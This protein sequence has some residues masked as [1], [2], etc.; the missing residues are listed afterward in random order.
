MIL[1]SQQEFLEDLHFGHIGE[2]KTLLQ[3][4]ECVY[5]PGIIENV[6]HHIR[7]CD[8]CQSTRPKQQK[9]LPILHDV[10]SGPWENVHT[11]PFQHRSNDCLLVAAYFSNFPLV[12]KLGNQ[13]AAHAV[14]LLK[15]IFS[16]HGIPAYLFT[17]EARQFMSAE[18]HE[19]SRFYQFEIL[20][21]TPRFPQSNGFIDAMVKILKQIISNIR[22]VRGKPPSCNVSLHG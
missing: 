22:A 9:D 5:W 13:T 17:D 18:F 1:T 4:Q 15:T 6:K 10:S 11:D 12:K 19:F 3:A 2:E 20:H 7:K 8:I 14:S 21:S 16:E